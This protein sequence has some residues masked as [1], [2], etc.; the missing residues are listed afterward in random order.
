MC[1]S[2]DMAIHTFDAARYMVNALSRVNVFCPEWEPRGSWYRQGSSA[3]A[4]FDMGNGTVFT[5]RGGWCADGFQTS[6]ESA[7]RIVGERGTLIWD[8]YDDLRAEAVNGT[9]DGL[10]DVLAADRRAAAHDQRD[11]VGGHIGIIRDFVRRH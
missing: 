6:W 11:A 8:G 7:W 9:R 10:F 2:L 4:I 5:Y 3:A 1:C